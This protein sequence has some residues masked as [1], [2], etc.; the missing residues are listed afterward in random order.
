[1]KVYNKKTRHN[2][3]IKALQILKRNIQFGLCFNL[4]AAIE[5]ILG[6]VELEDIDETN[7]DPYLALNKQTGFYPEIEKH[8][9]KYATDYWFR[10]ED[11]YEKRVGILEQ[12]IKETE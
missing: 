2:I 3:Y 12:A 9:P 10:Q 8:R 1:M 11:A 5:E 4:S 6:K 7:K